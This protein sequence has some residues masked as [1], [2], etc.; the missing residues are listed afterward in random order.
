MPSDAG[1]AIRVLVVDDSAVAREHLAH[2]LAQDPGMRIVGRARDGAEAVAEAE[3]LRPSVIVMDVHMPRLDGY[4]ATRQIMES[5]PTPIVMVSAGLSRDEV[6][7]TFA[8]LEAG[9]LAVVEK[10]AGPDRPGREAGAARL[11]ETVRLMSEVKVVRRWR[12]PIARA[13]DPASIPR[14][15]SGRRVRLV[16]IGASTGGPPVLGGML[17][18]MPRDLAAPIVIV[19]HTAP[20]F[21]GGLVEWLA[22]RSPLR[23]GLAQAGQAV[24]PGCVY[25]APDGMQ[26]GV[27]PTGRIDLSPGVGGDGFCPSVTHLFET[28][29]RS[30]GP[31]ALGVLLTGMGRDG[32]AGLLRM[33]EAGAVTAAQD[34]E[35]SVVFGMPGQA[36]ALGA[37]QYVLAPG[38]L[39]G[40]IRAMAGTT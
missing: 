27:T 24:Q 17:A 2:L 33:R 28:V 36:V 20:G 19:Q 8:A 25:V 29:A 10:P 15:T 37:A 14:A 12:T 32:A 7:M 40:L 4:Q 16:A 11:L 34:E 18:A 39:A 5:S 13:A 26:M 3:R 6:A 38:R 1:D 35:S 9:A 30:Y 31:G 22:A 21:V 23:V